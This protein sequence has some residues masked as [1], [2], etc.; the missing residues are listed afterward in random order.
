M[1]D[2]ILSQTPVLSNFLTA[3]AQLQGGSVNQASNDYNY[4]SVTVPEGFGAGPNPFNPGWQ[5]AVTDPFAN[6]QI[7]STGMSSYGEYGYATANSS[8]LSGSGTN[9]NPF[10]PGGQLT[11]A[12]SSD[13]FVPG[14]SQ[15]VSYYT[16]LILQPASNPSATPLLGA[17]PGA[18]GDVTPTAE[19]TADVSGAR[20]SIMG[21]YNL[22]GTGAPD[23]LEPGYVGGDGGG[24][25]GGGGGGSYGG[26]DGG[27]D[28]GGGGG[29]VVL[30]LSGK[31]IKIT[32]A[33]VRR[34][35]SST[36]PTT[37][38][39]S[40]PPGRARAMAC[41]ST[42]RAAGRSR[43]PT[44]SNS[45]CGIPA[46]KTDMQALEHVF[47]TNHD[48]VLNASDADWSDFYVL[49]T[50]AD[51]TQTLETMAQ[52]GVTSINLTANSYTA[53][54]HRRLV[55]RRRDHLHAQRTAR[56]ARRRPRALRAAPLA[57]AI[58]GGMDR[59]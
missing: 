4:V 48:G 15:T 6:A 57:A 32:T 1:F 36:W 2:G 17:L 33:V 44:R 59:A 58:M 47:D 8:D 24:G 49:V 31:G 30:D 22:M 3:Y 11:D 23:P 21:T 10:N 19:L 38:M 16:P 18:P 7:L 46:A 13:P 41:W 52:A 28:G 25:D 14:A 54:L 42:I 9:A 20:F 43:R 53:G 26:G 37:A 12:S 27:G 39:S 50:N 55:H 5:L 51:G 34:T 45:R 56:W 40:T 29:P 35:C